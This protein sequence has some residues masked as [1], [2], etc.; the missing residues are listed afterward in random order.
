MLASTV[1]RSSLFHQLFPCSVT[2]LPSEYISARGHPLSVALSHLH[3]KATTRLFFPYGS[4]HSTMKRVL[5]SMYL[6]RWGLA[7]ISC[8]DF[9]SQYA[10]LHKNLISGLSFEVRKTLWIRTS[11]EVMRCRPDRLNLLITCASWRRSVFVATRRMGT[12]G[13]K[14]R[15]SLIHWQHH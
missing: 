14:C 10:P 15:N 3:Y 2:T 12:W 8:S 1:M 9:P 13:R 6:L 11:S 5:D 7:I 4:L